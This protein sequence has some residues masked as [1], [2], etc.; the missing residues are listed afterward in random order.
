ME[1]IIFRV[2]QRG[3]Y[4]DLAEWLVQ[5]SQVPEQH[6]LHT[7]SGEGA[8]ELQQQ[9]QGYWDDSELCYVLALRGGR[10][11]GAMGCEY[12][13]ELQRGWLHGPHVTT[14]DWGPVAAELFTRLL[15]ALPACIGQL[16][17]FLNVE[18]KRGRRFYVQQ[19]FAEREHLSHEFWLTPDRR[20]ASDDGGCF[21]ISKEQE[22]SF[23]QL[24][25]VLFPRA[26]YSADRVLEMIGQSHQILVATEGELVL[27][28]AV[29]SAEEGQQVGEVQF[30]GVREDRR[31]QGHGRR[32]LLSALDWLLDIAGVS[33]VTLNV[34]EELVHAR[35]LYEIVGFRLRFT[36]IG[37]V[38][39]AGVLPP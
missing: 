20:V 12:D 13:E 4:R 24:Y 5:V 30:L 35:G 9:L 16:F 37:A 10:L 18:N 8:A 27:G 32:L 2:A 29:V 34:G 15:G 33:R 28:F 22:A 31:R 17:A 23:T 6:C 7:W 11:A 25:E 14:E 19:G 36:G 39:D 21:P 38:R 3:E 26:Y 1:E